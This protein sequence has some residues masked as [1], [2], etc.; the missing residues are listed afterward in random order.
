[1]GMMDIRR[2]VMLTGL[3]HE[4]TAEGNPLSFQ[5][6]LAKPLKSLVIPFSPV[7][8]GTGDPSPQNKRNIIGWNG[9][10]VNRTGKNIVPSEGYV[11]R[12][13][14][15][16]S[17]VVTYSAGY[18]YM[19]TYIKVKP[20][21]EY[22][23]T[24][25]KNVA[26]GYGFTVPYYDDQKQ[27]IS[28]DAAIPASASAGV[29]TF[30]GTITTPNTAR[31][32]RFSVALDSKDIQIEEGSASPYTPYTGQTYP[33]TF[34][35]GQTVYGGYVDPVN[36]VLVEEWAGSKLSDI[37]DGYTTYNGANCF[38]SN[39]MTDVKREWFAYN[40]ICSVFKPTITISSYREMADAQ[41]YTVCLLYSES[42]I[43]IKDNDH[44]TK[45]AFDT[46]YGNEFLC[47][48]L[49]TP[50]T[51]QL[52]PTQIE[53]LANQQNVIWSDTNGSNTAVYL[54]R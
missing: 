52:T 46:A 37:I 22:T 14:I 43:M 20:N 28:R 3:F 13:Y 4:E 29:G 42:R 34:P 40:L 16:A 39:S 27:F 24:Y 50:I 38:R 15:D 1:M 25:Y 51:Y 54:K 6:N 5:T 53:T 2:R 17:G 48:K 44:T 12:Y 33:V 21:T 9:T 23:V 36:G 10:T 19:E 11:N 7:Q 26:D 32:I 45:S 49:A 30:T 18:R 47:Y 31:Y 35:D 8:E 41:N